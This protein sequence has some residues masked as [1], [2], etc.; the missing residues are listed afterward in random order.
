MTEKDIQNADGTISQDAE[1]IYQSIQKHFANVK[2][3][4]RHQ[5]QV[6]HSLSH[7][8]LIVICGVT[9]GANNLAAVAE[10]AKSKKEW[11]GSFLEIATVPSYETLWRVFALLDPKSLM[12]SFMTWTQEL[13]DSMQGSVIAIDGKAQRGTADPAHPHSFVHIVSAWSASNKLTLGQLKVESKAN[14]IVAI[15]KLLEI[16]DIEG[17]IVTMDAMGCQ[18]KIAEKII[19]KKGDYILGLK[20]NQPTLLDEAVNLFSQIDAYGDDGRDYS[21]YET[22]ESGHGREERR[23]V[24]VVGNLDFLPQ[25]REWAGLRSIVRIHS[26][27]VVKDKATTEARYYLSSLP[28]SAQLHS[29][30]IR[31]HW[32][33]E[34]EVHWVLDVGYREDAQKAKA[35]NIAENM[36]TVR[37]ISLNMIKQDKTVKAGVEIKRQKAGWDNK[38]LLQLVKDIG[39]KLGVKFF[40]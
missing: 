38:F 22:N 28:S 5:G 6:I 10:Y 30:N 31:C 12:K 13:A 9:C 40:Q 27:R 25:K 11:L 36:A 26:T 14:E 2:D 4:R 1:I 7:I 29:E 35:G 32:G 21:K 15:P 17:A 24:C 37:R 3:P 8:L 39:H 23:E 33:I 20:D 19:E 16:L 34:N 18:T